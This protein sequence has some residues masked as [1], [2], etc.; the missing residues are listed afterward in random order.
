MKHPLSDGAAQD[1][2]AIDEKRKRVMALAVQAM[3]LASSL[4]ALMHSLGRYTEKPDDA[5]NGRACVEIVRSARDRMSALL[6][7]LNAISGDVDAQQSPTEPDTP[8]Q[9]VAFDFVTSP[10]SAGNIRASLLNSMMNRAAVF[11][12]R[13]TAQTGPMYQAFNE[14]GTGYEQPTETQ[15]VAVVGA[16]DLHKLMTF[17]QMVCAANSMT[18]DSRPIFISD[19]AFDRLSKAAAFADTERTV[20]AD[21]RHLI[22]IRDMLRAPQSF[23]N[24][25]KLAAVW[26]EEVR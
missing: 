5:A 18:S 25:A 14:V 19:D 6:D 10:N 12:I 21:P 24:P 9:D 8:A 1:P 17:A 16:Y 2:A 11:G 4:P 13:E 20:R 26:L 3:E 15:P 22:E 7:Q 23:N